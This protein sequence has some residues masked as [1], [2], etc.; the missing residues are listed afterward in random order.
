MNAMQKSRLKNSMFFP[1]L[2]IFI[3]LFINSKPDNF[4]TSF[5]DLLGGLI[6]RF[7]PDSNGSNEFTKTNSASPFVKNLKKKKKGYLISERT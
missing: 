5:H 1:H 4:L 2:W 3:R 6:E 7:T